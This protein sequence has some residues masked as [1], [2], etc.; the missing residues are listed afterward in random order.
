MSFYRDNLDE[1][2]ECGHVG[3]SYHHEELY[4]NELTVT[5]TCEKCGEQWVDIYVYRRSIDSYC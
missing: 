5:C 3:V 1:C 2:P 4:E